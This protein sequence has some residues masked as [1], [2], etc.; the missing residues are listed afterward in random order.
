MPS[1]LVSALRGV[2]VTVD[3]RDEIG[4]NVVRI[5]GRMVRVAT[6]EMTVR[7]VV[8]ELSKPTSAFLC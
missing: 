2:P 5:G 8:K 4:D 6:L 7:V 1:V 3:V